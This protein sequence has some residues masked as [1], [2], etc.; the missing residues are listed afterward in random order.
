M[1]PEVIYQQLR[2]S[3]KGQL[4]ALFMYLKMLRYVTF[5]W[6]PGVAIALV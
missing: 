6:E 3:I 5:G 2:V 1:N 4:A